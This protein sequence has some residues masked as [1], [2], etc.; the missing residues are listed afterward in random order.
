MSKPPSRPPS[1]SV[2]RLRWCVYVMSF[3][4]NNIRT[5]T[6]DG[7]PVELPWSS[8]EFYGA[9]DSNRLHATPGRL[10]GPLELEITENKAHIFA[11]ALIGECGSPRTVGRSQ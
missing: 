7:V 9:N 1:V 11:P 2:S 8:I 3:N 6:K 10:Y 5:P 4:D